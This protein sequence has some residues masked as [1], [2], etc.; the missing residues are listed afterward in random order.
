MIVTIKNQAS[1]SVATFMDSMTYANMYGQEAT[2]PLFGYGQNVIRT[3]TFI[4]NN[5]AGFW[6]NPVITSSAVKGINEDGLTFQGSSHDGFIYSWEFTPSFD[7]DPINYITPVEYLNSVIFNKNGLITITVST[8]T[9]TYTN[10]VYTLDACNT[11]LGVL[12]FHTAL[13]GEGSFWSRGMVRYTW[14]L[15]GNGDPYIPKDFA[16]RP[17]IF[18]IPEYPYEFSLDSLAE[19]SPIWTIN[20]GVLPGD[21]FNNITITNVTTGESMTYNNLLDQDTKI[22]IDTIELT[23]INQ[24]GIDRSGNFNGD[25]VRLINGTNN[26]TV[27]INDFTSHEDAERSLLPRDFHID[28]DRE[29]LTWGIQ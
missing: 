27:H 3:K 13:P 17:Y 29:I 16:V 22:I 7:L 20:N 26:Y 23:V 15:Y 5:A 4:M 11:E 14:Y 6:G 19:V 10:D 9:G 21:I 1:N 18:D 28:V 2:L 25:F 8:D 24:N 12:A